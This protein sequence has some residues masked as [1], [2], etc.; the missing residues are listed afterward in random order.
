M[1]NADL[2][3]YAVDESILDA[4]DWHEPRCGTRCIPQRVWSVSRTFHGLEQLTSGVDTS[5]LHQK[6]FIIGGGGTA[7]AV[8]SPMQALE[9]RTNFPPMAFWKTGLRTDKDGKVPF[10]FNAPDGLTK[11]RVIA[12]AQTKDSQFGTGSDRVEV[13]KPVQIEPALPRF[14]RVGD[15]VEL[16]AIVRQKIADEMPITVRCVTGLQLTGENSETQKVKKGLASVYRFRAKVGDLTSVPVRFETD[17]GP[18]DSV[19]ITVP[20][21]PPTLLRKE[22]VFAKL[23]DVQKQIPDEWTKAAGSAEVTVSTSP[24][25]PKLAG[26]PLLLEYPHGC[27]EQIT[28]RILCYTQLQSLLDY[29]PQPATREQDYRKRIEAGDRAHGGGPSTADSCLTG[30]MARRTRSPR[31]PD[32]GRSAKRR[33][34]T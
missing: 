13:A 9:C 16:R 12:L 6:G 20:V 18:G 27:F 1:A 17:A 2:T 5:S 26:L 34:G 32:A 7:K 28:S 10:S 4:G 8:M 29:L 24:W 19:E 30:R 31:S 25:L 3:V 33:L 22:S 14:L 21:F 11:Y 15:E 23:S